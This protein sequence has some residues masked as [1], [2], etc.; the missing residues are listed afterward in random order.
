MKTTIEILDGI[1]GRLEE[2]KKTG[3]RLEVDEYEIDRMERALRYEIERLQEKYETAMRRDNH[4]TGRD[5]K[6]SLKI[7]D[8]IM[9]GNKEQS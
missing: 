2:S 9:A 3:C 1:R 8:D 7:I 6:V 4:I 5:I